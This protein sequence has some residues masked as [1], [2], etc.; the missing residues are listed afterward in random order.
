[1]VEIDTPPN[2]KGYTGEG[3]DIQG[4]SLKGLFC[5]GRLCVGQMFNTHAFELDTQT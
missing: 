3:G 1:M 4:D 5:L 2:P